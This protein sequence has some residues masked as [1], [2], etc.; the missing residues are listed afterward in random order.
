MTVERTYI[1]H[2]TRYALRDGARLRCVLTF[3][4]GPDDR[5]PAVWKILV[6]GPAGI[7]D[8]YGAHEFLRAD[9]AQITAWLAPIVGPD[10]ATELATAV[11]ADPPHSAAWQRTTDGLLGQAPRPP[12]APACRGP[13]PGS[14]CHP[15]TAAARDRLERVGGATAVLESDPALLGKGRDAG[16]AT[17][18][19][20]TGVLH[21][22]EG[23]HGLIG[24]ALIVDVDNP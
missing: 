3:D 6:A 10:A 5:G 12:T 17:E 14:R 1:A 13:A 21:A 24:D 8:R 16:C 19:A 20:V 15:G 18:L 4:T 7:E 2:Q 11:D 23:G 9:A 22:A